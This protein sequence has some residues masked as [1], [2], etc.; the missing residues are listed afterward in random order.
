[1]GSPDVIARNSSGALLLYPGDGRGG[2]KTSRSIGSGWNVMTA[3]LGPGD[4]D[5]DGNRDVV[6]RDGSG[7]L[8]LYPGDGRGGWRTVRLIGTGW[9]GMTVIS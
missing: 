9:G 6:A 1:D 5:G 7:Q 3:I 4:V 8:L 2:W